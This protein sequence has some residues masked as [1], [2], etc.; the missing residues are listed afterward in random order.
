M[1]LLTTAVNLSSEKMGLFFFPSF[2]LFWDANK[3]IFKTNKEKWKK[4][5]CDIYTGNSILY[6]K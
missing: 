3:T 5:Q 1:K 2:S 6:L 4:T